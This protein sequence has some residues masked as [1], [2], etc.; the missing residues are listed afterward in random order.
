MCAHALETMNGTAGASTQEVVFGG[1]ANAVKRMIALI[2]IVMLFVPVISFQALAQEGTFISDPVENEF[3]TTGG[4]RHSD[5]FLDRVLRD[6]RTLRRCDTNQGAYHPECTS[7][8]RTRVSTYTTTEILVAEQGEILRNYKCISCGIAEVYLDLTKDYVEKIKGKL[9][10]PIKVLFLSLA[11]L[12]T[13]FSGM[14]TMTGNYQGRQ[15]CMD[16]LFIVVG[17]TLLVYIL[18]GSNNP[19]DDIS[20]FENIYHTALDVMGGLATV[21]LNT[22]LASEAGAQSSY[23]DPFIKMLYS[24]ELAIRRVVFSAASYWSAE[25]AGWAVYKWIYPLLLIIPYMFMLLLFFAK[26]VVAIFRVML[27]ALASPFIVLG[28]SFPWGRK[29]GA[30]AIESVVGAIMVMFAASAAMGLV[31]FGVDSFFGGTKLLT[32]A[33]ISAGVDGGLFGSDTQLLTAIALGWVG[34]G[35]MHESISITNSMVGTAFSSEAAATIQRG[36]ALTLGLGKLATVFAGKKALDL[37]GRAAAK[38]ALGLAGAA[39]AGTPGAVAAAGAA[40]GGAPGKVDRA[41]KTTL[42]GRG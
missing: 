25:G 13:V 22:N 2:L 12:W 31:L 26:I 5:A 1:C 41:I 16:L 21:A 36:G 38:G 17:W 39:L 32:S 10:G 29:V 4:F 15:F 14:K 42:A 8:L 6:V 24:C 9:I 30:A 33:D 18:G 35:L 3:S 7:A 27:I 19:D 34:A 40:L 28:F 20:I 23:N 37:G 11:L